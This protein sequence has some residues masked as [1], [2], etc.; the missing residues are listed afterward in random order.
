MTEAITRGKQ[1]KA[2]S[3]RRKLALIDAMNPDRRDLY[4]DLA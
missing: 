1:M 2:R 4:P 3:R